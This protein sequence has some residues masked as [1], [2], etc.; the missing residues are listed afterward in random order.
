ME[1]PV[2]RMMTAVML[3]AL[4]GNPEMST[5]VYRE[6]QSRTRGTGGV[7]LGA[8]QQKERT[9]R[10]QASKMARRSRKRNR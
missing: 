10:R 9:K 5:N 3:G 1:R 7:K 6:S 2:N 8:K 4:V